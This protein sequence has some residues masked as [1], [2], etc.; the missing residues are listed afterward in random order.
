MPSQRFFIYRQGKSLWCKLTSSCKPT[1]QTQL[2]RN[3]PTSLF[4]PLHLALFPN[5][6]DLVAHFR[7]LSSFFTWL[8][9]SCHMGMDPSILPLHAH[10]RRTSSD[11]SSFRVLS[12]PCL[13]TASSLS[14]LS[15]GWQELLY[16]DLSQVFNDCFS[17]TFAYPSIAESM[18]LVKTQAHS[19]LLPMFLFLDRQEPAWKP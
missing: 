12:W 17:N 18:C 15:T 16:V 13:W 4:Q 10:G 1:C 3:S 14:L 5:F 6:V 7:W 11:N 2:L 9:S 8:G 19:E